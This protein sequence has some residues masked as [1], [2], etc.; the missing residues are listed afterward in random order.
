MKP[1]IDPCGCWFWCEICKGD[2]QLDDLNTF[3]RSQSGAY[4]PGKKQCPGCKGCP[5]QLKLCAEH[6]KDAG[7]DTN[8]R[9]K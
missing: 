3:T 2:G 8:W 6:A 1:T 5:Q 9:G 4:V 7:F